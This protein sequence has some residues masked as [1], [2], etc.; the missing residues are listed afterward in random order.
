MVEAREG[1]TVVSVAYEGRV[2]AYVLRSYSRDEPVC[3]VHVFVRGSVL[4]RYRLFTIFDRYW[5]SNPR[6]DAGADIPA[7]FMY[8][9]VE[10]DGEGVS[11]R[12]DRIRMP[13]FMIAHILFGI[14]L[15][16]RIIYGYLEKKRGG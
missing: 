1:E 8:Y 13:G 15:Y 7:G 9:A 6:F 3:V 4:P 14:A 2:V 5:V 10:I 11:V 12:F 16:A